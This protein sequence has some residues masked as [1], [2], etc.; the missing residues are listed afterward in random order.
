MKSNNKKVKVIEYFKNLG[1]SSK[2]LI[3]DFINTNPLIEF[4]G[5]RIEEVKEKREK[6]TT[7][8]SITDEQ[9]KNFIKWLNEDR[10]DEG[11]YVEDVKNMWDDFIRGLKTGDFTKKDADEF[12]DLLGDDPDFLF[13]DEEA[14]GENYREGG[15]MRLNEFK[16]EA[17]KKLKIRAVKESLDI[18]SPI[19]PL[20][21]KIVEIKD[22]II[23]ED[24][25]VSLSQGTDLDLI[26]R[27]TEQNAIREKIMNTIN[28]VS[29][30]QKVEN[31]YKEVLADALTALFSVSAVHKCKNGADKSIAREIKRDIEETISN[32][33]EVGA[34][35]LAKV[36]D[37]KLR[38][39]SRV[40]STQVEIET[41][42]T[43]GDIA[44]ATNVSAGESD[45]IFKGI[46]SIVDL[47]TM[48][49]AL[50]L[51]TLNYNN[52]QNIQSKYGSNFT[53][54]IPMIASDNLSNELLSKFAKALEVKDLIEI[55]GM[56]ESTAAEMDG[57][58]V[59]TR[60][61]K[62]S[63]ILSPMNIELKEGAKELANT[64][65]SYDELVAAFSESG[66]DF[67]RG[68]ERHDFDVALAESFIRL[69]NRNPLPYEMLHEINNVVSSG[70]A[71]DFIEHRRNALPSFMTVKV[72]YKDTTSP[73]KFDTTVRN[74]ETTL[75]LQILPRKIS[76]SAI[77]K[78]LAE[79]NSKAFEDIKV[80]KEERNFIKRM[81]NLL[82]F[83]KRKGDKED[84][85]LLK[86]NAFADIMN[87]VRTVKTPLFH[88]VL[89]FP[90]YINLRETHK[91]DLMNMGDYKDVMK[92]LPLISITIIDE[93]S[94]ILYLSE[95]P[96]MSYIK[97][98]VDDFI[99]TVA[100]YEKELKTILKYNQI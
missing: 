22:D 76:S 34:V 24:E 62:G 1:K 23:F 3:T 58:S 35:D 46:G 80:T 92:K 14:F 72:E 59:V 38:G 65:V 100:Q 66:R 50:P 51:N 98:S 13:V 90:D 36:L 61:A 28:A 68:K 89:S 64:E 40:V 63:K 19:E 41:P 78:T 21:E 48:I 85:K 49:F 25:Q 43:F 84:L 33:E 47:C 12:A 31:E 74:R 69:I 2:E 83:W 9:K 75:G 95:G 91:I 99:D 81:S 32:V 42:H 70:E 55:K 53:F 97:H 17:L 39:V 11:D 5:D 56:I 96:V 44:E 29:T 10:W 54:K 20:N 30:N 18:I 7:L 26:L 82:G 27:D 8:K 52:I 45:A 79:L 87:K 15:P 86:S 6:K 37:E 60:A 67:F 71:G 94:D 4:V 93:D 88:M 77:I 16:N 57:G 73:L